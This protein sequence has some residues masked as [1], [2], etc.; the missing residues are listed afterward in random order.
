MANAA[1]ARA[2]ALRLTRTDACGVPVAEVTAESRVTTA[3]FI[4]IGLASDIF[5]SSD[6]QVPAASGS[7]CVRSK[8]VSSLLGYDVTIQLC[9]FNLAVRS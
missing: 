4:Q 2:N 6:I 8:G 7:I 3:G 1:P 5:T 9:D